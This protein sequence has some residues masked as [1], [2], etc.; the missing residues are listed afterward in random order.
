VE[1]LIAFPCKQAPD[2]TTL[3]FNQVWGWDVVAGKRG[4]MYVTKNLVDY[5]MYAPATSI[6]P[7]MAV[8]DRTKPDQEWIATGRITDSPETSYHLV[9]VT[10]NECL[11]VG[12]EY[13]TSSHSAKIILQPCDERLEQRWNAPPPVSSAGLESVNEGSTLR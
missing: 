6:F 12:A 11:S 7:V 10:R 9:S 3:T 4:R 5:C 13:D 1:W 2:S 8:C